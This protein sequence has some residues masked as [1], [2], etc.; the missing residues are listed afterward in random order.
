MRPVSS[1]DPQQRRSRAARARARSG[2]GPRGGRRCRSTSAPGRGGRGRSGRRSCPC[3]PRAG[4]RRARGTRGAARARR[5]SAFSARWTS[6]FL[7]TTSRPEVSRSSRCTIPARHGSP[8]AG[9]ARGQ[10]LGQRAGP[11]PAG[12]MHHDAR[13][14]CRRRA[15]ARPRRRPRTAPS[16]AGAGGGGLVARSHLDPLAAGEGVALGPRPRRRPAPARRRSGSGPG[17]RAQ[18]LGQEPVQPRSGR[19]RRD[20]EL[21]HDRPGVWL[22]RRASRVG[23]RARTAAPAPRR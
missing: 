9:P 12:R 13:P 16:V 17:P 10:R 20:L 6:S 14:A 15:G 21:D 2:S 5:S 1:D 19:L 18:R 3:G 8:A 23:P 22:S 7:A 4:P 11:V